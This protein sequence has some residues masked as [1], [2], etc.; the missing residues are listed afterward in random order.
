MTASLPLTGIPLN[1]PAV[2]SCLLLVAVVLFSQSPILAS[3]AGWSTPA[4]TGH[5]EKMGLSVYLQ[6]PHEDTIQC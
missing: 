5:T 2:S 3:P 1:L 6:T 4:A